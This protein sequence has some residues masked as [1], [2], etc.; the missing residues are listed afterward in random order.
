MLPDLISKLPAKSAPTTHLGYPYHSPLIGLIGCGAG[1]GAGAEGRT[2]GGFVGCTLRRG[3]I[4][5]SVPVVVLVV[6]R[7][8]S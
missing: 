6:S 4:G 7:I 5:L 2:E 3:T 1:K 8:E